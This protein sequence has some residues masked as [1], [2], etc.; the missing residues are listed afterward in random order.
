[1]TQF[2]LGK[3]RLHI[4]LSHLIDKFLFFFGGGG[5]VGFFLSSCLP[6]FSA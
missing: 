4:Y 6:R 2:N 5:G 3:I 1:M